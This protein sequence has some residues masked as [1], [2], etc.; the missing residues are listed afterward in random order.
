MTERNESGGLWSLARDSVRSSFKRAAVGGRAQLRGRRG[1]ALALVGLTA[2]GLVAG[3]LAGADSAARPRGNNAEALIAVDPLWPALRNDPVRVR[4][5]LRYIQDFVRE[6]EVLAA[7]GRAAGVDPRGV[8]ERT[9]VRLDQA[10][11]ALRVSAR[12]ENATT[13]ESVASALAGQ[14]A[15]AAQR[16]LLSVNFRTEVLGDFEAGP[17]SWA[18]LPSSLPFAPTIIRAAIGSARSGAG[19]LV[20]SCRPTAGCGVMSEVKRLFEAGAAYRI[21][22]WA[23]ARTGSP[24]VRLVVGAQA[25]DIVESPSVRLARRWREIS[26]LWRPSQ[27]VGS[28]RTAVEV[29]GTNRNRIDLDAVTLAVAEAREDRIDLNTVSLTDPHEPRPH[30]PPSPLSREAEIR[31]VDQAQYASVTPPVATGSSGRL[32]VASTLAGAGAG[33]LVAVFSIAGGAAAAR[34]R[35]GERPDV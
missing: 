6:P 32:P 21:T 2:G 27:P 35:F 25:I 13:A 8:A 12:D 29:A 17:G 28:A 34:R 19:F 30:D 20:A 26:V 1:V 18:A 9:D 5:R 23:R 24:S 7:A 4:A 33:F 14:L 10:L 11:A 15:A 16:A 22:A 3:S 31:A